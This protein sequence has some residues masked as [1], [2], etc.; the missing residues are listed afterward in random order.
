MTEQAAAPAAAEREFADGTKGGAEAGIATGNRASIR[1]LADAIRELS[2]TLVR[3]DADEDSIAE[4]TE[5]VTA[6]TA[7]L[8]GTPREPGASTRFDR[9]ETAG[10]AFSAA[11]GIGNPLAPPLSYRWEAEEVVA[12]CRLGPQYE[13]PKAHAHGGVSAL[14]LDD[15]LARIPRLKGTPRVTRS[16]EVLYRRPLPLDEPLVIRAGAVEPA[17]GQRESSVRVWGTIAT[18]ADP[19]RV[20]VESHAVFVLLRDDQILGVNPYWKPG[21]RWQD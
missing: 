8:R 3:F 14:L 12:E 1:A 18:A 19:E 15:V 5:T 7:C 10:K 13:G 6:V 20:L 9:A 2:A 4:A 21:D 17:P 16:L 11:H